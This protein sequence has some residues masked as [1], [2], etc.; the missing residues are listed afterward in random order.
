MSGARIPLAGVIGAPVAHSRSPLLHGHWLARHGLPGHYVP[1]HVEAADLPAV[2]AALPRAGFVGANVTIPHKEAVLAL[3]DEVTAT[4]RRIGAAN[5]LVFRPDGSLLADN[6]DA[7]GFAANMRQSAPDWRPEIGPAAVIGAGGA[8]RAIL[9]ALL[10]LDVPRIRIANRTLDRAQ[11]LRAEFGPRIDVCDWDERS[12]MLDGAVT[13]VNCSSLGM[14]GKAPLE[15]A[16]DALPASAT[17]C[18][19]V[20]TPLET[21]LLRAARAKGCVGVDGLGMLLHQAAP[22]FEHWFGIRPEVDQPLRDLVL[23]A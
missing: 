23:G 12:D 13:L 21:P 1:L 8:A 18:D 7:Y 16:L 6:T 9:A 2:L 3:A 19:I 11:A 10:D 22:A 15:I 20:Y 17:V 5:T 14:V 4:A